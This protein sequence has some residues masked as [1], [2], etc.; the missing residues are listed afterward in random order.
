M[1]HYRT[2]PPLLAAEGRATLPVRHSDHTWGAALLP[3]P[4]CTSGDRAT[5]ARQPVR[6]PSPRSLSGTTVRL[7]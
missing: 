3:L 1:H 4:R 6:E 2:A 7:H 5:P